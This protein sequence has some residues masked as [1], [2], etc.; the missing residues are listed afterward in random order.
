MSV[1]TAL[2]SEVTRLKER[3]AELVGMLENRLASA[4]RSGRQDLNLA[5]RAML[6]DVRKLDARIR[7]AESEL[8]R[9]GD[10]PQFGQKSGRAPEI[11]GD[12]IPPEH[13]ASRFSPM[14]FRE[15]DMRKMHHALQSRQECAIRADLEHRD[16]FSLDSMLPASL[17]P[18]PVQ[19]V[20]HEPRLLDKFVGYSCSTPSIEFIQ[21]TGTTGSAGVMGEGQPKP[22]LVFE[23]AQLTL[24]MQKI[25]SRLALSWEI[26]SDWDNFISYAHAEHYRLTIVAEN[27]QLING[28][29]A[30][31][32]LTGYIVNYWCA[33]ARLHGGHRHQR[34]RHRLDSIVAG[35]IAYRVRAGH[36]ESIHH[37]P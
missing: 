12:K 4:Q 5:E 14:R 29:G 15:E 16:F 36:P 13:R 9:A 26:L 3:K 32:Q 27:E 20:E 28:T 7:H 31:G 10:V 23:L 33:D 18:Y 2:A 24:P 1:N 34:N 30:S 17:Y 6:G 11:R 37:Q 19:V 25:A 35:P 21:H 22:E 8:K